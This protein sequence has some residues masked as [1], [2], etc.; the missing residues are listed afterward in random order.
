MTTYK[1]TFRQTKDYEVTV[2][3]EPS[4]VSTEPSK[5]DAIEA[6]RE[7]IIELPDEYLV[8]EGNLRLVDI[9]VIDSHSRKE[10]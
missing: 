4:T 9:E 2:S 8:D 6:G 5:A 7:N 10:D 3:T 1:M